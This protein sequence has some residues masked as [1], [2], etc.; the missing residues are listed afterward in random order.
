MRFLVA[1]IGFS[2]GI[3]GA[4]LHV[5]SWPALLFLVLLGSIFLGGYLFAKRSAYLFLAVICVAL[6]CGAGRTLVAPQTLPSAFAPLVGQE[7]GLEGV[8]ASDPDVRDGNQH[9]TIEVKQGNESTRILAFAPLYPKLRYGEQV[10]VS[11]KLKTPEPFATDGGRTFRYDDYLAKDGIFSLISYATIDVVSPPSGFL[12]SVQG[13][14]FSIK[15][16]FIRTL[17]YA[18]PQPFAGLGVGL[19]AGGKQ[20]I[21]KN[22]LDAFTIAGLLPIV[23]LSGY[24]VMIVAEGVMRG[25][26]FLPKGLGIGLAGLVVFAF[27]AAAGGGASALRAGL[28]AGLALFARGSGRTYDALRAL[29]IVFVLM[30]LI[31]PLLLL[32]DPG[33]QFSFAATLGLII[34]TPLVE[35]KLLFIKSGFLR[36]IIAT[37]IAAQVAVLPLLLYQTG[38]L[39]LVAL[40]AN[41]LVLPFVPL[42]MLLTF[43]AG[44][45]GSAVPL[46]AP[47][48]AFPAFVLL[49]YIV[50]VA[51]SVAS[52]PFAHLI[53]PAFPFWIVIAL[54]IALGCL[55]W[56]ALIELPSQ[57]APRRRSNSRS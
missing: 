14:L 41:V 1:G 49:A 38:N 53:I 3:T 7:V 45:V 33:F 48:V 19:V 56:R 42:T 54:Y 16:G 47:Y 37:T 5:F 24:N 12:T 6:A 23:V 52:L 21:D 31:N 25:L 4:S 17:T 39:S 15:H 29:G 32:N 43:I 13:F 11:G 28:M 46:V 18:M 44:V 36:E 51:R 8:I 26:V 35:P 2:L 40:P 50:G 27:I 55:V 57:N 22:T 30:L 10:S 20:G 34:G 9:V